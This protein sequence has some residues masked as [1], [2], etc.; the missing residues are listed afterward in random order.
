MNGPRV[1]ALAALV[2]SSVLAPRAARA[3]RFRFDGGLTFSRFEQQVKTEV[4]G[5]KGDKLVE[6]TAFG[7]DFAATYRIWKPF[8]L[9]LFTQLDVG[10]RSAARFTGF[11][12][13]GGTVTSPAVGGAY[14]EVWLGPLFRVQWR[15]LFAEVGYGALGMR[16]DAARADLA[17]KQGEN[18]GLFAVLPSVAWMFTVGGG[19]PI[20][21]SLELVL[22]MEYR[23][24]YYNRRG[25]SPL[26]GGMVH[27]SQ[28]ITPFMGVAW[29]I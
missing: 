27:G 13:D 22:R 6:E 9:G 25:G 8:S 29:K 26:E 11:D 24:R 1:A 23:I 2:L 17:N 16:Q 21:D 28:N 4:G 10:S 5:A 3:E 20:T 7:L 15:T 19:V 18:G 14:F 12:A